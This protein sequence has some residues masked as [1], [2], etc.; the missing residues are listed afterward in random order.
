[1][2]NTPFKVGALNSVYRWRYKDGGGSQ[3][4]RY[5][6]VTADKSI[7]K[8]DVVMYTTGSTGSIERYITPSATSGNV[9][10]GAASKTLA[11][12]AV[13]DKTT[14]G[15]VTNRD[16]VAVVP[17]EKVQF[18]ARLVSND[19]AGDDAAAAG[20]ASSR[21]SGRALD[22]KYELGLCSIGTAQDKY[23][24]VIGDKTDGRDDVK[25]VEFPNEGDP[26]DDYG[27]VWAELV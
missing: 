3:D 17:K 19:T 7:K 24:P 18:L 12:I 1:M 25:V 23:F 2:A 6:P 5:M 27:L 13:A 4:I 26:T 14:T 16:T 20:G 8:G 22:D 10:F 11:G 15:T 9:K 21:Q